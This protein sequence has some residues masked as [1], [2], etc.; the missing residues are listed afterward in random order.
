MKIY[1]FRGDL[2]DISAKNRWQF[3]TRLEAE[4]F[5]YCWTGNYWMLPVLNHHDLKIY[6]ATG[7][8]H[9]TNKHQRW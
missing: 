1:N 7:R 2:T 3:F 4:R 8:S 5:Q 9:Q 6:L